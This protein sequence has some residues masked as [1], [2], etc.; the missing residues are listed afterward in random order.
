V[1]DP[2]AREQLGGSIGTIELDDCELTF[3]R[4]LGSNDVW[5][6]VVGPV[7]TLAFRVT[8]DWVLRRVQEGRPSR[9]ASRDES[10]RRRTSGWQRIRIDDDFL[11][12][13]QAHGNRLSLAYC[14]ADGAGFGGG[15]SGLPTL[16]R[17]DVLWRV[18]S[19]LS[20]ERGRS[21]TNI[22]DRTDPP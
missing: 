5:C 20:G 1:D 14:F 13:V 9:D 19:W 2:V 3:R 18:K 7:G 10:S 17:P 11:V 12:A 22:R 6:V 16:R 15:T 21:S 4:Q 8:E